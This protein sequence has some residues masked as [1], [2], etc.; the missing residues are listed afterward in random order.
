MNLQEFLNNNNITIKRQ[1][2]S[3]K[4]IAINY[5]KNNKNT[6]ITYH[7]NNKNRGDKIGFF[8]YNNDK[9]H[10]N[11]YNNNNANIILQALQSNGVTIIDI[12]TLVK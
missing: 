4:T 11:E 1:V 2:T 12:K 7:K 3:Y 10:Y 9:L 6:V 8:T 5:L